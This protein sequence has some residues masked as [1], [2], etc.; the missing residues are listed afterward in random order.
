MYMYVYICIY[1][2]TYMS[3]Y[4]YT[5]IYTY[6]YIYIY[7]YIFYI[8]IYIHT[9]IHIY[10]HIYI[11]IS[12]Y[13]DHSM[14]RCLIY[15]VYADPVNSGCH[16]TAPPSSLM[17]DFFDPNDKIGLYIYINIIVYVYR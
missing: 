12:I 15:G 11:Y 3:I 13:S 5:C 1:I 7:I 8:H 10:I 14:G 4:V 16:S 17:R 9:Y 6:T 2:C